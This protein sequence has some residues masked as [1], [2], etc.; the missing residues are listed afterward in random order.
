[1]S[2][3]KANPSLEVEVET[4]DDL[5]EVTKDNPSPLVQHLRRSWRE[6]EAGGEKLL[7]TDEIN[8][9]VHRIR[10]GDKAA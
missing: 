6:R 4:E 5:Q 7:T 8:R 10:H 3:R 2:R 1:M 9:E